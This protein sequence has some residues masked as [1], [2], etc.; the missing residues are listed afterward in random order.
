MTLDELTSTL[1]LDTI[2][3]R[4]EL[5]NVLFDLIK[6]RT[7]AEIGVFKGEFAAFVLNNNL[8]IEHYYMIDPWV[9]L[10]NWNKPANVDNEKF[11]T[12]YQEAMQKTNFASQ[13]VFVL[14]GRTKEIIGQIP[15]RSLDA[16][17][18]DGDHTL[19]GI[20]I[21]LLN[22]TPKVK[23]GGFIGG[24]DFTSTPWQHPQPY[25]PTLVCPFSVY[26]AEAMSFPIVAL[27]YNQ[28]V[29]QKLEAGVFSFLDITG[30]YKDLSLNVLRSDRHEDALWARVVKVGKYA[31]SVI[32]SFK[33]P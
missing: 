5:W 30:K 4:F 12:I 24:D 10:P 25:E 29:I 11:E 27:P 14:R 17:Y 9:N 2:D 28:F 19:R 3:N 18:I 1:D 7:M 13:K 33:S 16:V 22:V 6:P 32:G 20:T 23:L 8:S 31:K 21:D 15:D 26:F